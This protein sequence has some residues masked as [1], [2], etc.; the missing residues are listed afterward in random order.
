MAFLNPLK[1]K[2]VARPLDSQL[3]DSSG[4]PRSKP[5]SSDRLAG[6]YRHRAPEVEEAIARVAAGGHDDI[7]RLLI[8]IK[9]KF[10]IDVSASRVAVLA[11]ADRRF[12]ARA[13]AAV[14][15]VALCAGG[16]AAFVA[17]SGVA[18][19]TGAYAALTASGGQ[20]GGHAVTNEDFAAL[21]KAGYEDLTAGA[22]GL[23]GVPLA[24]GKGTESAPEAAAVVAGDA[25]ESAPAEGQPVS[26]WALKVNGETVLYAAS[27]ESGEAILESVKASYVGD[28]NELVDSSIAEKVELIEEQSVDP[29]LI[30]ADEGVATTYILTGSKEPKVYTVE[31]GDTAWEIAKANRL[32]LDELAQANPGLKPER[33]MIGQQLNLFEVNPYVTVRTVEIA[34]KAESIPFETKYENSSD[35]YKGQ[36][37]VLVKGVPGKKET[38]TQLTKENGLVVDSTLIASTVVSD[39]QP[40]L[41]AVGTKSVATFTGTG[42]LMSPLDRIEVSSAYGSRGN[43]RHQG[44]DMRSP[45]GTPI[46]AADD[47]VVTTAQYQGT[48]GNLVVLSHGKGLETYY[49]HCSEIK[50]S[51]GQVV[52]KGELI[53]LVGTTGNATGAHL[54][55]EVRLNGVYQNPMNYF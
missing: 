19:R 7:E 8:S 43:R 47:G 35:M 29:A 3:E 36:Q 46:H 13:A 32:T 27:K 26:G 44:V 16:I 17:P 51:V 14:V 22:K 49:A 34:S 55:F 53:G 24:S 42:S 41:T 6:E 11:R 5:S 21:L 28:N 20:D 25:E 23:G 31:K 45:K 33:L 18:A 50:V 30:V 54:H 52:S 12:A 48:Y 10:R 1:K 9:D 15:C 38:T 37:K 2:A 39:P 40:Q 4:N